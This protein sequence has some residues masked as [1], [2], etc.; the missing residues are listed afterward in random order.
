MNTH[1]ILPAPEAEPPLVRNLE[2]VDA[3]NE[4]Q[5]VRAT[6]IKQA[7]MPGSAAIAGA[8]MD[9]AHAQVGAANGAVAGQLPNATQAV[10]HAASQT[11]ILAEDL[12]LIEKEWVRIAKSV[13]EATIGDPYAQNIEINKVKAD[14]I[15]KRYNKAVKV[16]E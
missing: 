10:L 9:D 2:Q 13:V 16:K 4:T 14:Y 7:P 15:Q 8:V 12:D 3:A 11:P 1:E 5:A 6:E